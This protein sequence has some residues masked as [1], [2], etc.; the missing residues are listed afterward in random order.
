MSAIAAAITS[1]KAAAYRLTQPFLRGA[2]L[3]S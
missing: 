3:V 1:A 2:A